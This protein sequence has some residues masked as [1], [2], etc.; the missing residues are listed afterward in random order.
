MVTNPGIHPAAFVNRK[1]AA[2]NQQLTTTNQQ[3]SFSHRCTLTTNTDLRCSSELG[4][5]SH[6]ATGFTEVL[7][8]DSDDA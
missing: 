2:L 7:S 4:F 3:L 1:P 6:G 8:Q 5:V